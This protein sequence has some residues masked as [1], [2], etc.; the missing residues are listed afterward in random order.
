[1]SRAACHV[2]QFLADL[3]RVH[4][5]QMTETVRALGVGDEV[6]VLRPGFQYRFAG[7]SWAFLYV[8]D[9]CLTGSVHYD[10]QGKAA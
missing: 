2:A 10:W 1:M 7:R 3:W 6:V 9:S 5:E 4:V 8:C